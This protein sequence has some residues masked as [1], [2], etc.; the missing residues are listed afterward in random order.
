MHNEN[1]FLSTVFE[2]ELHNCITFSRN[3]FPRILFLRNT[4]GK[5]N[6]IYYCC[7]RDSILPQLCPTLHLRYRLTTVKLKRV[8][9]PGRIPIGTK[10]TGIKPSGL[11]VVWHSG[12]L[13]VMVSF[14]FLYRKVIELLQNPTFEQSPGDP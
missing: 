2:I 9:F 1:W 4:S 8:F 5:V 14:A 6:E 13:G 7:A 12:S 10:P 3:T 11:T